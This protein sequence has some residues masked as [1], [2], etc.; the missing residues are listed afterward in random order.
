[1]RGVRGGQVPEKTKYSSLYMPLQRRTQTLQNLGP[2][3][4]GSSPCFEWSRTLLC[5]RD[6][7]LHIELKTDR[8]TVGVEE[9]GPLCRLVSETICLI[10]LGTEGRIA[11]RK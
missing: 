7:K 6:L 5:G 1:M 8:M 9:V 11:M 2:V 4:E 10:S 3:T